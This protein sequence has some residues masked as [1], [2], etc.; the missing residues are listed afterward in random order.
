MKAPE[1]TILV[2]EDNPITRKMLRVTLVAEGYRV[3]EA[4]TA[5]PRSSWRS[6]RSRS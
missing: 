1:I 4:V 3:V 5:A 2:V 6:A